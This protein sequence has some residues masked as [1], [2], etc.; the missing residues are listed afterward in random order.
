[1]NSDDILDVLNDSDFNY[2]SG[3]EYIPT[4]SDELS[5]SSDTDVD[6]STNTPTNSSQNSI[7]NDIFPNIQEWDT[8]TG[9]TFEKLLIYYI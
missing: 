6:P 1:M 9:I 7:S 2:D 5:D 8:V 4:S 3:S